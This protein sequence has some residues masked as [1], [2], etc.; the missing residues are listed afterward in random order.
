M[1]N[2]PAL[3]SVFDSKI[4]HLQ[5][6]KRDF[7]KTRKSLKVWQK[8]LQHHL[9]QALTPSFKHWVLGFDAAPGKC[10][11]KLWRRC[12][13]FVMLSKQKT[14][15][16]STRAHLMFYSD[17]ETGRFNKG[18]RVATDLTPR[19]PV[20]YKQWSSPEKPHGV[21]QAAQG[22]RELEVWLRDNPL[23]NAEGAPHWFCPSLLL[24]TWSRWQPIL[25]CRR[26]QM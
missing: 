3:K 10:Y 20:K 2:I 13:K 23:P 4:W 15:L 8:L 18:W 14:K 5:D 9:Q 12:V 6:G 24:R 1:G 7:K 11:A 25:C 26:H 22:W 17:P 21:Q 16:Y 19:S